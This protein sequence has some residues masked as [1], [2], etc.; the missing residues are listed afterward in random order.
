MNNL[1]IRPEDQA[2]VG[3]L[4]LEWATKKYS[5]APII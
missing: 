5:S 3:L 2:V 4:L 1:L